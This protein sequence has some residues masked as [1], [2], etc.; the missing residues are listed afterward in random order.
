[1]RGGEQSKR[2]DGGLEL[3]IGILA[4]PGG[5]SDDLDAAMAVLG[6]SSCCSCPR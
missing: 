3:Q 5:K 4:L 6:A 1:M 2:T